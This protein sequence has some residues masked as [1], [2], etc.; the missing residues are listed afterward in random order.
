[1]TIHVTSKYYTT[2]L[3]HAFIASRVAYCNTVLADSPQASAC[4][5]CCSTSHH[6]H[7]DILPR[8]VSSASLQAALAGHP[9]TCSVLAMS[10][11]LSVP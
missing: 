3:L 7:P 2:T 8:L 5:E 9:A 11:N 10:H 1:M 4:A 6:W